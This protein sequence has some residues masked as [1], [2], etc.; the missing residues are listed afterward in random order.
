[1]VQNS[2]ARSQKSGSGIWA[3]VAVVRTRTRRSG[4][5]GVGRMVCGVG[6]PEGTGE[7]LYG[8]WELVAFGSRVLCRSGCKV[9]HRRVC[10]SLGGWRW[11]GR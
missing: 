6:M 10:P 3:V 9:L 11:A 8:V 4:E 5:R 1:M 7:A 2:S